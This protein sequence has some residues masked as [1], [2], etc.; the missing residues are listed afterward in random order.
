[1]SIVETGISFLTSPFGMIISLAVVAGIGAIIYIY[2]Y[3]D[4]A[5][6]GTVILFRPRD[7]RAEMIPI[8][9]EEELIVKCREKDGIIRRYVK[10]GN[11]WIINK[12]NYFLAVEGT[13]YTAL[14]NNI[15]GETQ[16][17]EINEVLKSVWG[18]QMYF[19]IP[20]K[21]RTQLAEAKIMIQIEPKGINALNSD[22]PLLSSEDLEDKNDSLVLDKLAKSVETAKQKT[23]YVELILALGSGAALMFILKAA[24]VLQF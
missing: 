3:S 11:S 4:V 22:L 1:M 9:R 20:E 8:E 6:K 16:K 21:R 2:K 14:L 10:A 23:N 24:G 15:T 17:L 19:K 5:S 18:E 12:K 7:K 13:G